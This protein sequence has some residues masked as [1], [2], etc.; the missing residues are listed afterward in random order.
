MSI[1]TWW[2]FFVGSLIVCSS[3]G[4]NMLLMLASG[5][6]YG[7]RSTISTMA[8]CLLSLTIIIIASVTGVGALLAASPTSFDILKTLGAAYLIYIGIRSCISN[9]TMVYPDSALADSSRATKT[10]SFRKGFLVGISNPKAILFAIAFFPQFIDVSKPQA[11]QLAILFTTFV[12]IECSCYAAYALGGKSLARF[13]ANP[14][15]YRIFNITV[16]AIFILFGLAL[17]FY[18]L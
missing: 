3:P 18:K 8:G 12:I 2:T 13:L 4:P 1:E 14:L 17:F 7:F 10:E 15:Y 5:A 6:R 9:A 11:Q 16:G